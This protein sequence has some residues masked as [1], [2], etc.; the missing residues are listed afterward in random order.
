MKFTVITVCRNAVNE[1]RETVESVLNQTYPHIEYVII[2]G[3]SGDGTLAVLE[4]YADRGNVR[5][6]SE[7]DNGIY[8]A[9]NR[10]IARASGDYLFF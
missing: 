3:A 4:E 1:I 8:N 5:V 2:D 10:G 7:K 6:Y 9:M